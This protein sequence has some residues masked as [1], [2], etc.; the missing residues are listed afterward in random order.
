MHHPELLGVSCALMMYYFCAVLA[1][2]FIQLWNPIHKKSPLWKMFIRAT[3]NDDHHTWQP[4]LFFHES[5]DGGLLQGFSRQVCK[6][7]QE[8]GNA[9]LLFSMCRNL[10]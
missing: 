7:E 3:S 1:G 10:K 8:T 2:I 4:S 6:P 9:Q 5:A